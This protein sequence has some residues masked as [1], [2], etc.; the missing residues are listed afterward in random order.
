MH[1]EFTDRGIHL[2]QIDLWLDPRMDRCAAAWISHA[3][4]DHAF[5]LHATVF[6]TAATLE[7]YGLRWPADER[8]PQDLVPVGYNET[9]EY[10]GARLTAL[11]AAHIVGA[12][13]L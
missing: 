3:H 6:A 5:G 12:A 4:S 11:R 1:I 10:R 2:P 7:I 8:K 13:Q 9:I